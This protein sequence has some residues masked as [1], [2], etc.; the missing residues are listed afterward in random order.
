M[1]LLTFGNIYCI[2][3]PNRILFHV[4]IE[5]HS[6]KRCLPAGLNVLFAKKVKVEE[7][8]NHSFKSEQEVPLSKKFWCYEN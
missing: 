7:T 4:A 8:I 1:P 2:K 5:L 3:Y 6:Y